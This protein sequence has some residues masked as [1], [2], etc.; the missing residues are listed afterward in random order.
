MGNDSVSEV[1]TPLLSKAP[2]PEEKTPI[3]TE[4]VEPSNTVLK[5]EDIG[6]WTIMTEIDNMASWKLP[7]RALLAKGR[8]MTSIYPIL[9]SFLRECFNVSPWLM[10]VY[11]LASLWSS[12]QVR[13]AIFHQKC[14]REPDNHTFHRMQLTCTSQVDY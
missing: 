12:T 11:L 2:E 10:V 7:G 4:N 3:K 9:Y 5:F 8:E 1:L 14:Y 6:V 13:T